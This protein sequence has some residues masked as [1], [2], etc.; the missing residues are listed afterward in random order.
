M[1]LILIIIVW[2]LSYLEIKEG[3]TPTIICVCSFRDLP[4]W[5]GP[6]CTGWGEQLST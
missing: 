2:V 4:M 1:A 6:G 3:I 5:C